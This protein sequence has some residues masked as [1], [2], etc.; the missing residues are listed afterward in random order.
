MKRK[1]GFTLARHEEVGAA[2]HPM[3]DYL[4]NLSLEIANTYPRNSREALAAEG[5]IKAFDKFKCRM[6]AAVCRENPRAQTYQ[7]H[8]L[9]QIYYRQQRCSE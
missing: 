7:G 4:F 8:P 9:T 3:R 6:D 5:L 2:L 1:P